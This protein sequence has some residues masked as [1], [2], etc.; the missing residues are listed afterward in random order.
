[1]SHLPA[2]SEPDL[3]RVSTIYP[4]DSASN[5]GGGSNVS[6]N[7]RALR[8]A[9]RRLALE[10]KRAEV[11]RQQLS[12]AQHELAIAEQEDEVDRLSD[13][14]SNTGSA[15]RK[16]QRAADGSGVNSNRLADESGQYLVHVPGRTDVQAV[17]ATREATIAHS[18]AR[19]KA[20]REAIDARAAAAHMPSRRSK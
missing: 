4:D 2:G 8:R 6:E 11:E 15:S 12:V 20:E 10:R 18:E 9:E 3:D 1:M 19:R 5:V 7:T 17:I 13:R 16:R 14:A